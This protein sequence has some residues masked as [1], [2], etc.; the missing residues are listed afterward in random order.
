[1]NVEFSYGSPTTSDFSGV[2]ERW[3]T[4]FDQNAASWTFGYQ[5]NYGIV[6]AC[7]ATESDGLD[8]QPSD[9]GTS[10]YVTFNLPAPM[11]CI[12]VQYQTGFGVVDV[13]LGYM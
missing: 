9:P 7:L 12:G 13:W 6:A 1:M 11:N 3:M 10:F 8:C 5:Y 2:W 4:P